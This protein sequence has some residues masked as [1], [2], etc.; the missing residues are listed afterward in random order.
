MQ[1]GELAVQGLWR[2][3]PA[4]VQLLGLCPL[5]AVSNTVANSLGLGVATLLVLTLSNGAISLVR[6]LLDDST[7]LPAQIMV[8]ATFVTLAEIILQTFFFDLY[9]R[10]GLFVALIVTNCSLLGRA[11]AFARRQPVALALLDGFMMGSGFLLV[12]LLMGGIREALGQGTLFANMQSIFGPGTNDWTIHIA[13]HGF[14]LMLLP[15]GAFLTLGCLIA[16]KNHIESILQNR[17]D[18]PAPSAQLTKSSN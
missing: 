16:A 15:P 10:I 3:N 13:H 7:R 9:S 8:I 1:V 6:R 4:L 2:N 11:E 17:R 18:V 14:L 5:L 12:I